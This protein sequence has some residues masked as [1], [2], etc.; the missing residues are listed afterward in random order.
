MS[1]L[2]RPSR[3]LS[4]VNPTSRL[5]APVSTCRSSQRS[6]QGASAVAQDHHSSHTSSAVDDGSS[7]FLPNHRPSAAQ[8][9]RPQTNPIDDLISQTPIVQAL[10]RDPAYIESR[11]H[12]VMNPSLRPNHFI[13]GPNSGPGKITVPPYVWMAK[14]PRTAAG[15]TTS[16]MVSVFHIGPQLCGHPGFVHGGLLTVMFDEAFARCVS[17]SFRSGLGM[18]ANLNVDFRKP[19]LPD[20]LY[21]LRAETVKVEGRKAWVEGTLTSLPPVGDASEPVMVAEGK[22]LFVEPKFAERLKLMPRRLQAPLCTP[23]FPTVDDKSATY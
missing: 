23:V 11:P 10:R 19:A 15:T 5:V 1:W 12:L 8:R 22:A 16:R 13:A 14:N 9:P 4:R 7:S 21:V 17:T 2:A 18:T 3:C 20:R 6:I